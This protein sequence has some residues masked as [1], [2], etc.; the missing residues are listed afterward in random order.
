MNP[1]DS[2]I[3]PVG[4]WRDRIA[5]DVRDRPRTF[6]EVVQAAAVRGDLA[7]LIARS[8]RMLQ[9]ETFALET[10]LD[11]DMEAVEEAIE[12]F[13][14][15]RDLVTVEE[16]ERWLGDRGF[17]VD[18]LTGHFLRLHWFHLLDQTTPSPADPI[19]TTPPVTWPADLIL[20]GEIDRL[21]RKLA[22]ECISALDHPAPTEPEASA[23]L[24]GFRERMGL[25][26]AGCARWQETT[27]LDTGQLVEWLHSQARHRSVREALL[28]NEARTKALSEMRT[29]LC[30]VELD[31]VEFDEPSTARE[32]Y[33]CAT[34]DR[35]TMETVAAESGYSLRRRSSFLRDL[36]EPWRMAILS[37][38]PGRVLR[39]FVGAETTALVRLIRRMDAGL[40]DPGV[41]EQL[42]QTLFQRHFGEAELREIRW[43][44]CGM[45]PT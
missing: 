21:A 5:F 24:A 7:P 43:R 41:R 11:P 10:A 40:D 30:R 19:Q 3:P 36:P 27:G 17:E 6:L 22:G 9:C 2:L 18:D 38:P 29:S 1:P 39:P 12:E 32:A 4:T 33:Q 15:A 25:D 31:V 44:L 16:T 20:S 45:I 28:G 35:M 37:A 14:Y 26:P 42:D 8:Q 13:R 23:L 34:T